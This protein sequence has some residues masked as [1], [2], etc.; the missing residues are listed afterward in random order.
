MV[1]I[2]PEH[3]TISAI[4]KHSKTVLRMNR[5]LFVGSY[6]VVVGS[7][8]MKRKKEKIVMYRMIINNYWIRFLHDNE[9]YQGR[10]LCYLAKPKAW[11]AEAE[12][13]D[14]SST[15]STVREV[16]SYQLSH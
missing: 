10:G 5:P 16:V 9:N 13:G 14:C 7:R 4:A 2:T 15:G 6:L 12:G 1:T 8:P 11:T 3:N